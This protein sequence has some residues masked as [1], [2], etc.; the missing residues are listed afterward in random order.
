MNVVELPAGQ[1]PEDLF[2]QCPLKR[3]LQRKVAKACTSCPHFGGFLE[4]KGNDQLGFAEHYRVVCG[5][6]IHRQMT[7]VEL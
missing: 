4:V 5:C 1:V 7:R 3:F 2:V 6:P